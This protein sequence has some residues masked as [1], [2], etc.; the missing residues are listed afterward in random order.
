MG[1]C[2]A[3]RA[4]A[5]GTPHATGQ[6]FERAGSSG[7]RSQPEAQLGKSGP[8]SED[9]EVAKNAAQLANA[10]ATRKAEGAAVAIA[11]DEAE[12]KA[13]QANQVHL[14]ED[15]DNL[16]I[17]DTEHSPASTGAR[18][19]HIGETPECSPT[20][21][22]AAGLNTAS[23]QV[24]ERLP[25]GWLKQESKSNPGE[26]YYFCDATSERQWEPPT[27]AQALKP[28]TKPRVPP[29]PGPVPRHGTPTRSVSPPPRLPPPPGAPPSISPAR[30]SSPVPPQLPPGALEEMKAKKEA[31][32]SSRM[33]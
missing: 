20:T 25:A 3:S 7:S 13:A 28:L 17:S 22:K 1:G 29:P 10:E 18:S 19:P 27:E 4:N 31:L 16:T 32:P 2:C 23:P 14:E 21:A 5:P 33:H 6:I 24:P 12:R 26:F 15:P 11:K 9:R 30:A 8:T